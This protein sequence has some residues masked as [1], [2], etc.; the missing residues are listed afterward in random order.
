M[1][2]IEKECPNCGA[3]L[4]FT[5]EDTSCKCEY[6]KREFEIERDTDKKKL[7]DQFSLSELKTPF[8]IFS[9]LTFGSFITQAII[10]FITFIIIIILG[11][12]IIQGLND[13]DSIFNRNTSLIENV[14]EL[15]DEDYSTIDLNSNVLFSKDTIGTSTEYIKKGNL[16]R[17]RIYVI[18]N[19]KRNYIIPVYKVVYS[20]LMNNDEKHILYVPIK[21]KNVKNKNNSIAF[22]LDNG[23]IVA[24]EYYFNEAQTEY[25]Y[26]YTD[27]DTLYNI[28]IKKYEN[29]Y[30]ITQK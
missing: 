14:S 3:S 28:V 24:P 25:T 23:R 10:F 1:R 27:I 2:L 22:S 30:K 11:I 12:N 13:S 7:D 4:S 29:K 5:K 16:K 17:E 20:K 9:Y 6:C 21:Y 26:G 15:N 8:K 18:S 19:K